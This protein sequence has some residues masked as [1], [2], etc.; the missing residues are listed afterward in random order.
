MDEWI[1]K[2]E[3]IFSLKKSVVLGVV[4]LFALHLC[5]LSPHYD[6]CTEVVQ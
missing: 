4:E 1:L 3:L 6:S 2:A 5:C